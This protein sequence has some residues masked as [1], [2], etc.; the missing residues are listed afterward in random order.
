MHVPTNQGK[1]SPSQNWGIPTIIAFLSLSRMSWYVT[2]HV[3]IKFLLKI[4]LAS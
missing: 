4:E 3:Y 1:Y 2:C